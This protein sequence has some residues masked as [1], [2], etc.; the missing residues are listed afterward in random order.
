MAWVSQMADPRTKAGVQ[1]LYRGVW[2]RQ[3]E[4]QEE[5]GREGWE[6]NTGMSHSSWQVAAGSFCPAWAVGK[7]IRAVH[8]GGKIES[9]YPLGLMLCRST[10]WTQT[11]SQVSSVHVPHVAQGT[12]WV[13]GKLQQRRE[14]EHGASLWHAAPKGGC[15]EPE[16][17][18]GT[19]RRGCPKVRGGTQEVPSAYFRSKTRCCFQ[20]I[21]WE[22]LLT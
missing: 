21:F 11:Y 15:L 9:T 6:T 7:P 17:T 18:T 2:S 3:E 19:K 5:W 20:S 16:P 4:G 10:V 14:A 8:L 12:S 13:D 1:I 22:N